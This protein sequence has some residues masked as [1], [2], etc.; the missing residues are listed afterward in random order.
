MELA[1]YTVPKI[2]ASE[3]IICNLDNRLSI[4]EI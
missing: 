2:M 3:E 1:S 4:I